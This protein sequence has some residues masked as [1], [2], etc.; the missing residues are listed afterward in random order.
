ME[1]L[2]CYELMEYFGETIMT[3]YTFYESPVGRLLLVSDRENLTGLY[4]NES[5]FREVVQGEWQEDSDQP[6]LKKTTSQLDGYF[7]GRLTSF[8][9]PLSMKG[10]KFQQ[11]VWMA[12]EEIPFGVTISYKE[13][14]TRIG[15]PAASRAVGLANGRNPISIIV[16]C[17]RV[18]GANGKL[19]GYGG[20]IDRKERLLMFEQ[21]VVNNGPQAMG[22][23]VNSE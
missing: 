11:K 12:L 4:M 9:L 8:D 19:V 13:L 10:T 23:T 5:S 6:V 7:N 17:H 14:A 21:A 2:C 20:G 16:P 22:K 18:I 1:G 15:N 3:Y